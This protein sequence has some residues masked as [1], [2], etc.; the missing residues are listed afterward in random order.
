MKDD[1]LL[2]RIIDYC[3]EIEDDRI[4]FGDTLDDFLEDSSYQRSCCMNLMQI[5]EAV[6]KLSTEL[7]EQ[8]DEIDWMAVVG[9]RN[10]VAH[11]YET[12]NRSRIWEIITEDVPKLMSICENVLTSARFRKKLEG[13]PVRNVG[14]VVSCHPCS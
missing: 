14:F 10:I 2:R 6:R 8:H 7:T 3:A 4:R 1:V 11:R 13:L 5:G 12:L 9:F